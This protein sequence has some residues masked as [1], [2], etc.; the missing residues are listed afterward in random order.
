M[1]APHL[2]EKTGPRLTP[3]GGQ[4]HRTSSPQALPSRSAAPGGEPGT[5]GSQEAASG[6]LCTSLVHHPSL[7][8]PP[9]MGTESSE[10]EGEEGAECPG[11]WALRQG[12]GDG[13]IGA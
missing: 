3:A 12:S 7:V 8:P 1:L 5:D 6:S 10:G 2:T 4:Q 13:H 11:A 9:L